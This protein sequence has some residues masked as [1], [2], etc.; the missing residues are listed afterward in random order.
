MIKEGLEDKQKYDLKRAYKE[1]KNWR[2]QDSRKHEKPS[3]IAA[4]RPI[5][6]VWGNPGNASETIL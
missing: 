2:I 5:L 6:N 4:K 1:S 3:I